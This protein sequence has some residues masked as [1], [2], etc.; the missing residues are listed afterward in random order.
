DFRRRLAQLRRFY[1]QLQTIDRSPLSPAD[2]LTYDI[3]RHTLRDEIAQLEFRSYLLP[4]RKREGFHVFFADLPNTV[5]LR[6]VEDYENYIARLNGFK[7]YV[8]QHIELMRTGMRE[9]YTPAKPAWEGA[10]D[11]VRSHVVERPEQSLLFQPF[12]RFPA[13]V[14]DAQRA[15][16]LALGA[17]AV[18]DSVVEGY[19]SL[20]HFLVE[21]YMPAAR[22]EIAAAA[23]PAGPAY[24]EH[25]VRYATTLDISPQQVHE[26][27][28]AE[29]E[30]IRAEM[31]E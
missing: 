7:T 23:L 25:C 14:P 16:L 28:V 10:E 31:E 22:A 8:A 30:R 15:R 11:A 1:Q 13:T 6:T 3:F 27:G 5:P 17:A 20:L 19:R 24:Y 12:Q 4:M 18:M 9:G 29:V 2:R 21:A 26:M